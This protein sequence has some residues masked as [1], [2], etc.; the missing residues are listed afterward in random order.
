MSQLDLAVAAEVSQRHVSFLETGRSRPSPEMAIHLGRS[1]DLSLRDCNALLAAAGYA[2]AY[3]ER[4]LDDP[5]LDQLRGVLTTLLEAY[6]PFPAY[7]VDRR[8]DLVMTNAAAT[9]LTGLV[10]P[11]PPPEVAANALRLT[12][13]PRGLRPLI[14]N[15]DQVALSLVRRLGREVTHRPF[16]TQ[17][18]ALLDEVRTYPG[19]D[20]LPR[21]SPLPSGEDLV[22]PVELRLGPTPLRFFTTITTIGAAHDI[23]LEELRLETLLPADPETTGFLRGLDLTPPR[24]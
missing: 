23:T 9:L 2:P 18:A 17:L 19:V 10:D 16:D 7:V 5:D 13:H 12:L 11:P 22:V 20:A 3:P 24:I 21:R 14:T 15:W 1:L 4:E 6:E 8:W